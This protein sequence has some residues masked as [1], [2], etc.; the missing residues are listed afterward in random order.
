MQLSELETVRYYT[1]YFT[2]VNGDLVRSFGNLYSIYSLI[3]TENGKR[4]IGRTMNPRSRI[5]THMSLL[6]NG[7]HPNELLNKD[8]EQH[9]EFQILKGSICDQNEAKRME[10]YYM[11]RYKT[12][13]PEFGY[14]CNDPMMQKYVEKEST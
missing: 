3:N 6:K 14:N 2:N 5:S 13:D 4:Y 10:R 12:Y 8:H 7:H 11:V 9:F 1:R